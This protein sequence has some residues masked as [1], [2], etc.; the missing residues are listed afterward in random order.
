MTLIPRKFYFST[1][2][3]TSTE[4][5]FTSTRKGWEGTG[6]YTRFWTTLTY[7]STKSEC[8]EYH[9]DIRASTA[10]SWSCDTSAQTISVKTYLPT[11]GLSVSLF[12]RDGGTA[13]S[14][15]SSASSS[16][17]SPTSTTPPSPESNN[18][19]YAGKIAGVVIAVVGGLALVALLIW[20]WI[21]NGKP[22]GK[23]E[24][25]SAFLNQKIE[26][27]QFQPGSRLSDISLSS[28]Y[29]N[30]P[31]NEQSSP[32]LHE[33]APTSS[34]PS[35]APFQIKRKEVNLSVQ[36]QLD[37]PLSSASSIISPTSAVGEQMGNSHQPMF[38]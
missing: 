32:L 10:T 3:F 18:S 13:T 6:S 2:I 16:T 29:Q 35:F 34:R 22:K 19:A 23:T 1:E 26:Q 37:H 30:Q 28:G 36:N 11:Q 7:T 25:E 4:S 24:Q 17:A 31:A 27:G 8:A 33:S 20:Y 21:K 9:F 5:Y 14:T 38:P 12:D 15:R